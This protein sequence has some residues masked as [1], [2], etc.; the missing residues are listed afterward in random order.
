MCIRDRFAALPLIWRA[1]ARQRARLVALAGTALIIG[2]LFIALYGPFVAARAGAGEESIELRSAADRAVYAEF[3]LRAVD[4]SPLVG[5]G[6]GNF[7]WRASAYLQATAFDLRG[8]P[9]HHIYL[10]AF[11]ELGLIGLLLLS[12]AL[13]LGIEAALQACRLHRDVSRAALTGAVIALA[14]VGLFDHYPWTLLQFQ[15]LWWGL[16]GA[17]GGINSAEGQ[18]HAPRRC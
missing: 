18:H 6:I 16:L 3:A 2:G 14:F 17:L 15:T 5:L 13:T 1:A 8:Q 11:A 12:A 4:E 9:V 7:A 10:L